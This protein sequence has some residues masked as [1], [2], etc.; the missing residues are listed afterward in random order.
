[1]DGWKIDYRK[2]D[3]KNWTSLF[4]TQYNN[5]KW[6]WCLCDQDADMAEVA[7]EGWIF[8]SPEAAAAAAERFYKELWLPEYQATGK[9]DSILQ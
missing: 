6:G 4:V 1:M 5:G 7:S 3:D 9:R 2:D 8:E